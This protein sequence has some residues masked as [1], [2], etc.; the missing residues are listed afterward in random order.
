MTGILTNVVLW[1]PFAIVFLVAGL[2]F[3]ISGY[4]KGVARAAISAGVTL[5]SA[6]ISVILARLIAPV[7]SRAVSDKVVDALASDGGM[8]VGLVRTIVNMF[9]VSSVSLVLFGILIF[10]LTIILNAITKKIKLGEELT[11]PKKV[12]GLFVGLANAIVFVLLFMLPIYGTLAA[13]VPMANSMLEM[14][15]GGAMALLGG[16]KTDDKNLSGASDELPLDE[17]V[18]A[19]D[20]HLLIKVSGSVPLAK[21]YQAITAAPV[22]DSAVSP[23][24]IAATIEEAVDR[25]ASIVEKWERGDCTIGDEEKEF[26]KFLDEKIAGT[27]WAYSLYS[28]YTSAMLDMLPT[29]DMPQ[30]VLDK[31]TALLNV[32]KEEF[33][34]TTTSI[35]TLLTDALECGVPEA[36]LAAQ[37]GEDF[38]DKLDLDGLSTAAGDFLNGSE[39]VAA[40]KN[41]LVYELVNSAGLEGSMVSEISKKL[42][43]G[44]RENE[45][46]KRAEGE[47]YV[48][49]IVSGSEYG[50]IEAAARHPDIGVDLAHEIF[51]AGIDKD[52]PDYDPAVDGVVADA[53]F[54]CLEESVEM[55]VGK[56]SFAD[57]AEALDAMKEPDTATGTTC[58]FNKSSVSFALETLSRDYFVAMSVTAKNPTEAYVEYYDL[59]ELVV[60]E[61]IEIVRHTDGADSFARD[62]LDLAKVVT[63]AKKGEGFDGLDTSISRLASSEAIGTYL[64]GIDIKDTGLDGTLSVSGRS[65]I[66]AQLAKHDAAKHENVDL[67]KAL[68]GIK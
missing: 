45:D 43:Y 26:I 22:A 10:I 16:Q 52:D 24:E 18:S 64:K 30:E 9:L 53:I 23:A 68:F 5:V 60:R 8:P 17:I 28:E 51:D 59:M 67:L 7:A 4:K 29:E 46:D 14:V 21:T 13:Y 57:S 38:I 50:I 36:I 25:T 48:T 54:E 62:M 12:C 55:D 2:I 41:N 40:L 42:N 61:N 66:K 47:A 44:I 39:T 58:T 1:I 63:L 20:S 32:S 19:V 33:N 37:N 31:T 15:D 11:T 3:T 6:V 35:T 27:D 65:E 56:G 34:A 49:A